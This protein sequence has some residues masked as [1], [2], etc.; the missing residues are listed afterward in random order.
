[1]NTNVLRINIFDF[2]LI[3]GSNSLYKKIFWVDF[4]MSQRLILG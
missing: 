3:Y 1:M 2:L 4:Y